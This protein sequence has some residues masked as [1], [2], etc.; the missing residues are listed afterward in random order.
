MWP[1][2]PSKKIIF[3]RELGPIQSRIG[4]ERYVFRYL[5]GCAQRPVDDSFLWITGAQ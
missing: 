3:P 1:N 4:S 2:D 5:T